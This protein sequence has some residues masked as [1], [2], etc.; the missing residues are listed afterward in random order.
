FLDV[1]IVRMDGHASGL[2]VRIEVARRRQVRIHT[3]DLLERTRQG[4]REKA[5]ASIKIQRQ[6]ALCSGCHGAQQVF[7]QKTI[8]LK[9]R[10]MAHAKMKAASFM[11][12]ESRPR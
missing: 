2:R 1:L 3:D 10:K 6:F 7:D 5:N 11:T 9:K 12:E 8:H 4:Q